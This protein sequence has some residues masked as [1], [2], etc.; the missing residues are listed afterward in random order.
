M[1]RIPRERFLILRSEV[2]FDD[3][4]IVLSQVLDFL[5]LP[6]SVRG[7]YRKY[8]EGS[9]PPLDEGVRTRLRR[10]YEPYNEE[11]AS[12]LSMNFDDWQ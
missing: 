7:T 12:F 2:F 4:G 8:N 1:E 10:F 3:P 11:L 5:G 9:Y 6:R